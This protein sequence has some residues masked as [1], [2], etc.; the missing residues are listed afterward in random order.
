[1]VVVKEFSSEP[2]NF[3]KN[4]LDVIREVNYPKF[5]DII[6]DFT[7]SDSGII[8]YMERTLDDY[9]REQS[10]WTSENIELLKLNID[11]LL[12]KSRELDF[13]HGNADTVNIAVDSDGK[14]S[15]FNL[16]YSAILG[17]VSENNPYNDIDQNQYTNRII[18][19]GWSNTVS[20]LSEP[21]SDRAKEFDKATLSKNIIERYNKF[22]NDR[23]YDQYYFE[24]HNNIRQFNSNYLN[25]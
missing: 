3:Q 2:S 16:E 12:S 21:Y 5:A 24:L 4:E 1:M 17:N 20:G 13:F 10:F 19:F 8:Y 15:W 6:C 11:T 7:I 25:G 23:N 18:M 9:M 22:F 14:L